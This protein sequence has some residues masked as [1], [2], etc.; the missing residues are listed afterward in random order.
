METTAVVKIGDRDVE[1]EVQGEVTFEG[2]GRRAQVDDVQVESTTCINCGHEI[3][4][5]ALPSEEHRKLT[6][7]LREH[8]EIEWAEAMIERMEA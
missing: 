5:D 7:A 8:A 4:H 3:D 1:V 6:D 2:R